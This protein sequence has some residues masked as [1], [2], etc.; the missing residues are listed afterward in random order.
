VAPEGVIAFLGESGRG[1][2]TLA[3]SLVTRGFRFF[4]DDILVLK[5]AK[6]G[7][8]GVPGYFGFRLWDDVLPALFGKAQPSCAVSQL[9]SKR[10][11]TRIPGMSPG[12]S[13]ARRVAAL[14][15]LAPPRAK[16]ETIRTTLLSARDR[17]VQLIRFTY[18]MD[19]TDKRGLRSEFDEIA[20][21][22]ETVPMY[23]IE[24]PRQISHLRQV[25]DAILASLRR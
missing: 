8:V 17:F 5:Q 25:Q 11:L 13:T 16:S 4:S 10:R 14:F 2:S 23:S 20:K 7:V 22:V 1:K 21:I 3:A 6:T 24:Y 19:V 9:N 12:I 18:L 15:V